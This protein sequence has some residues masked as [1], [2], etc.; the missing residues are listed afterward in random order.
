MDLDIDKFTPE[1]RE[2]LLFKLLP[3]VVGSVGPNPDGIVLSPLGSSRKFAP[4]ESGFVSC[5]P[6]RLCR[7]RRL[8]ILEP[9]VEVFAHWCSAPSRTWKIPRGIWAI[10]AVYIG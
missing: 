7:P 5:N 1:E 9:V 4:G 2:Q 8:I 10:S 6:R 3:K